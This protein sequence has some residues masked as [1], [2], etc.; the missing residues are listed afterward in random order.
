MR[1]SYK[2]V[3]YLLSVIKGELMFYQLIRPILSKAYLILSMLNFLLTVNM[4]LLSTNCYRFIR[5]RLWIIRH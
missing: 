3:A 5:C 1:L 2:C 4:F